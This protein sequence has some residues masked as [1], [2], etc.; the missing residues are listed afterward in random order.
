MAGSLAAGLLRHR[1]SLQQQITVQNSAGEQTAVWDEYASR[2]AQIVDLS[3][4]HLLL[5]QQVQS[6]VKTRIVLRYD[7]AI[8][9]SMRIVWRTFAFDIKAVQLDPDSG[10]EYVSCMCG[11]GLNDG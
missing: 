4:T 7:A 11:R 5:A 6:E 8:V 10:L 9:P 2:W 1:V 3:G